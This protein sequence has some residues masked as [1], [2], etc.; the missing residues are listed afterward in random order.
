MPLCAHPSFSYRGQVIFEARAQGA[1]HSFSQYKSDGCRNLNKIGGQ[2]GGSYIGMCLG[3]TECPAR[4]SSNAGRNVAAS[5]AH[6][7]L[8]F[9]AWE[10][11]G[12]SKANVRETTVQSGDSTCNVSNLGLRVIELLL[13]ILDLYEQQGSMAAVR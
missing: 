3:W 13:K 7:A 11:C 6:T 1:V 2:G 4:A 12:T 9:I 8:P 5:A 10:R